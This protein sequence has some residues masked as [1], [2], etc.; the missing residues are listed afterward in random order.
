MARRARCDS[1]ELCR[2]RAGRSA[3][4]RGVPATAGDGNGPNTWASRNS[5]IGFTGGWGTL[6]WGIWDTPWK[7]ATLVTINPIKGSFAPDYTAILSTP[8]FG[9]PAVNTTSLLQGGVTNAAF[10]R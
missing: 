3:G 2:P 8:G 5:H 7:W 10:Y 4:R 6:I 1:G 9:V